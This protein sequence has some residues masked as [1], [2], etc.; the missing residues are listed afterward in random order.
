MY[1]YLIAMLCLMNFSVL[2]FNEIRV[3]TTY[4]TLRK[5]EVRQDDLF[6]IRYSLK[7]EHAFNDFVEMISEKDDCKVEEAKTTEPIHNL[8]F[9]EKSKKSTVK[10][11]NIDFNR[12]PNNSRINLYGF[13][14][15]PEE[16]RNNPASWYAILGR[17]LRKNYLEKPGFPIN[18][19]NFE[20]DILNAILLQK[21]RIISGEEKVDPDILG[22]LVFP[23]PELAEAV[24]LL[25]TGF[26]DNPSIL[27]YLDYEVK[28]P[29]FC[30]LNFMFVDPLL[31]SAVIDH[32]EA[33]NKLRALQLKT[34]Q[35]V[36]DREEEFLRNKSLKDK[37]FL[38]NRT[39]FKLE[40]NESVSIIL[41]EYDLLPIL[42]KKLFEFTLGKPG[43]YIF[44]S[45]SDTGVVTR[46]C[47]VNK[48][49]TVF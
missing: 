37:P 2:I 1:P 32:Q 46:Y 22:T 29:G 18:R 15:E 45:N 6:E 13:L 28:K 30:K 4:E 7:A 10:S 9:E 42:N 36:R 16:L 39:C 26:D 25:L 21:A 5:I 47:C 14:N 11:L 43:D 33:F 27:N 41:A 34:L 20:W 8:D 24:Y 35:E 3:L 40:L 49:V 23:N 12:L 31:L 44:L 38:K 48:V 19:I 17:F